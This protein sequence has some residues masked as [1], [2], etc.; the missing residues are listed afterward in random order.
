MTTTVLL[1]DDEPKLLQSLK[2][3]LYQEPFEILTAESAKEALEM[4][5]TQPVDVVV[6][7]EQM[8]QMSGS[9]L[10]SR[11]RKLY[12]KTVRIMLTG[13]TSVASV[14]NAI[15]DGCVYRYLKKPIKPTQLVETINSALHQ[16]S[17]K[18][19]DPVDTNKDISQQDK[20][21][22][23][24]ISSQQSKSNAED[25]SPGEIE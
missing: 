9:E 7:D 1:V 18:P 2:A 12:P 22:R 5:K 21:L 8:P 20:V 4:L 11:V 10:L 23:E 17:L 13:K 19:D 16:E 15:Y 3:A 6:S 14:M 24:F 25:E